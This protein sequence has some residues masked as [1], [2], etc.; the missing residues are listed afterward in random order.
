MT[1]Q[2]FVGLVRRRLILHED[3][4]GISSYCIAKKDNK[5]IV[6]VMNLPLDDKFE[7]TIREIPKP[8]LVGV[9]E[10]YE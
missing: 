1:I 6:S 2:D 3:K 4:N 8:I 9:G 5:L 7:I 10:Y